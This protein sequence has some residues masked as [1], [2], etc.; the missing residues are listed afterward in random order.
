[1]DDEH[2]IDWEASEEGLEPEYR[3]TIR[4][5]T[6]LLTHWAPWLVAGG[7]WNELLAARKR[8]GVAIADLTLTGRNE[9]ELLVTFLSRGRDPAA[10]EDALCDWAHQVGYRRV[11]LP[12]RVVTLDASPDPFAH[13]EVRCR[14]CGARWHD[15]AP[16]F[17]TMVREQRHFPK[18][19]FICGWELPQWE[20][21]SATCLDELERM[22]APATRRKRARRR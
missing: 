15:S 18:W 4:N 19:C 13:A 22:T 1:M 7:V 11:W 3:A 16:D 14:I 6:V 2:E 8:A 10:A 17:W 5:G 9:T 20:V 21:R 12:D